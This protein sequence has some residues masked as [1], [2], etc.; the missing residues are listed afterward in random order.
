MISLSL[1]LILRCFLKSAQ[2]PW[3]SP[4][5]PKYSHSPPQKPTRCLTVRHK[6]GLSGTLSGHSTSI[7]FPI[8]G[9]IL[10]RGIPMERRITSP[11][12][13]YAV[14]RILRAPCSS[15]CFHYSSFA[16]L[17][18]FRRSWLLIPVLPSLD[19][20]LSIYSLMASGT[21]FSYNFYSVCRSSASKSTSFFIVYFSNAD[22]FSSSYFS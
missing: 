2:I 15:P 20:R 19:S 16:R 17:T 7:R 3:L 14:L 12:Y 1:Y 22:S 5:M 18:V 13:P 9:T 11:L 6:P 21:Y 4:N 8:A 10:R